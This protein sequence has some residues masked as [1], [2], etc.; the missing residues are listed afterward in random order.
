MVQ[1]ILPV[2][3]ILER[4][5]SRQRLND[6]DQEYESL[7]RC[8]ARIKCTQLLQAR[9]AF[10]QAAVLKNGAQVIVSRKLLKEN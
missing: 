3:N 8:L 7:V 1:T 9:T 5:T 2:K 10:S 6:F 4:R